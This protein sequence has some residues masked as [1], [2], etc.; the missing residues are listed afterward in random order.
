MAK[1]IPEQH[2]KGVRDKNEKCPLAFITPYGDDVPSKKR[3]ETVNNWCMGYGSKPK[4]V[5]TEVIDNISLS[6]FK[7]SKEIRRWSTSNGVWRIEDPRG[8]ELE[9][10]SGNMAYLIAECQ[11]QNGT[12]ANQLIWCRDGSYNYLLPTSS[13][14]YKSYTKNTTCIKSG[15]KIRD[16][17]IGDH[18]QLATGDAGMYLGGYHIIE[19]E[20]YSDE[21]ITS[22][23]RYILLKENGEY[24]VKS[25]LKDIKLIKE[26]ESE[27]EK[28]WSSEIK[29]PDIIYISKKNKTLIRLSIA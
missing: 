24:I 27:D 12:I 9:I 20:Q 7:I 26:G 2:F 21:F 14:E 5:K 23:R 13:E 22:K 8:F 10:T 19:H 3:M 1:Y 17:K 29:D 15:L 25:G 16:I 28:D 4:N 6:G 11:I 18:I